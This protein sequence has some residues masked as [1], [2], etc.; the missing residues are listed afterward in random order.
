MAEMRFISTTSDKVDGIAVERGN[1]IFVR[2]TRTILLDSDERVSF[3]QI[4]TLNTESQRQ[5]LLYPLIGFYFIKDTKALWSFDGGWSQV[6]GGSA[7]APEH[8]ELYFADTIDDF[9]AV[10]NNDVL[11][12]TSDKT[13]RWLNNQYTNVGGAGG[14]EWIEIQ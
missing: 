14:S 5:A 13:Y 4:I 10:G 7:P 9:P 3:S 8:K 12:V 11:Y 6:A 2:D 1:L